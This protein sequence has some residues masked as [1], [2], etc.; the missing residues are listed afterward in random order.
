[1]TR[2][3]PKAEIIAIAGMARRLPGKSDIAARQ[4]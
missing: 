4:T 2:T 3:D 1:M